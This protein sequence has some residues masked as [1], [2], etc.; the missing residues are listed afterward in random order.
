MK[1]KICRTKSELRSLPC[2]QFLVFR[3]YTFFLL[4]KTKQF[5]IILGGQ[6]IHIWIC[7]FPVRIFTLVFGRHDCMIFSAISFE[8][9]SSLYDFLTQDTKTHKKFRYSSN[10]RKHQ[11]LWFLV[12]DY[13]NNTNLLYN[14]HEMQI[15]QLLL[16]QS[17][18]LF[19]QRMFLLITT[20]SY[21]LVFQ[22]LFQLPYFYGNLYMILGPIFLFQHRNSRTLSEVNVQF[23]QEHFA[24]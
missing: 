12:Q 21:F 24:C 2:N 1:L 16:G 18:L 10:R 4:N 14:S 17:S 13:K 8:M 22:I 3:Q 19:S 23:H 6:L 9:P 5:L 15:D 7:F 11:F 20:L